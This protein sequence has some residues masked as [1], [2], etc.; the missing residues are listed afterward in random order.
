MT[1]GLGPRICRV[2]PRNLWW[3]GAN[4]P[5]SL[6][7]FDVARR[8]TAMPLSATCSGQVV[9]GHSMHPSSRCTQ[10][11]NTQ[12]PP[13]LGSRHRTIFPG[14]LSLWRGLRHCKADQIQCSDPPFSLAR[15][16]ARLLA[17]HQRRR[18]RARAPK[19]DVITHPSE[20]DLRALVHSMLLRMS[21]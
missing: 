2:G 6:G 10:M 8:Q 4:G 21:F 3:M 7:S 19:R 14:K 17:R 20:R 1:C 11:Q 5:A 9:I 18:A 12:K 15:S 16:P 13:M